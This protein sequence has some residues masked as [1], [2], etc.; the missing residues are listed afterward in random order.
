ML[1]LVAVAK[2]P[3]WAAAAH[4]V[5]VTGQGG[6]ERLPGPRPELAAG[7]DGMAA[8]S[9]PPSLEV[10]ARRRVSVA[11]PRAT[12]PCSLVPARWSPVVGGECERAVGAVFWSPPARSCRTCL[13][14]GAPEAEIG[15]RN[16]DAAQDFCSGWTVGVAVAVAAVCRD[17][18]K[19]IT[20]LSGR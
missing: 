8:S 1:W 2:G 6:G 20:V 12:G 4:L 17:A 18:A 11:R 10:I 14:T 9:P 5:V 16:F 15:Q 3:A 13:T 19:I 7:P